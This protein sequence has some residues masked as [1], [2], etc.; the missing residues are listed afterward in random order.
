MKNFGE[1]KAGIKAAEKDEA[2]AVKQENEA[3]G[4][5]A[6]FDKQS[7]VDNKKYDA[8]NPFPTPDLKPWKEKPPE[9]NPV[10]RFGSWASAFG[11]LAGAVTKTGLSSSLNASASAMNA[12]R[13]NDLDAYDE[14]HK[15]WKEN[16][17]VASKQAEWEVKAYEHGWDLMK[18]NQA[19]GQT[20][21]ELA[22]TQ[23]KNNA[24]L[25]ALKKGDYKTA[26]D[27]S[28]T[29]AEFA[30]KAPALQQEMGTIAD[31]NRR[32]MQLNSDEA[33][34][35]GVPVSKLPPE[36]LLKNRVQVQR[37]ST[38]EKPLSP[39]EM[40]KIQDQVATYDSVFDAMDQVRN[41]LGGLSVGL[42]GRV[43]RPIE[44]VGEV[45]GMTDETSRNRLRG[46][47]A[48]IKD[49]LP[50]LMTGTTRQPTKEQ[51]SEL[52][53]MLGGDSTGSTVKN[54]AARLDDME[55]R[56]MGKY[57]VLRRQIGAGP[58]TDAPPSK[59][60]GDNAGAGTGEPKDGDTATNKQTGEKL[61]YKAGKW[62]PAEGAAPGKK[63]E[64]FDPNKFVGV[65]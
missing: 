4:K 40:T 29:M 10:Q 20:Q 21:L 16:M 55:D 28:H 9:N 17:E 8:A 60:P 11:I 22:A 25:A 24:M 7:I 36:I 54:V 2:A 5:Q 41:E 62:Q 63:I 14:A 51:M 19:L 59:K 44:D 33:Q 1:A 64:E 12:F 43:G 31:Q 61:V 26:F 39:T 3:L 42:G 38:V 49:N 13:K 37:E 6:D 50:K 57:D 45:L 46:A 65:Q 34:K 15:A 47:M 52:E 32:L 58:R 35:L 27:M 18:T 48:Y 23:A 53:K 56:L 30:A